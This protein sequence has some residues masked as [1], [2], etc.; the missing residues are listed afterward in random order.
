VTL[1]ESLPWEGG[2][3]RW[4]REG[5]GPPVVLCHGTPWSSEVWAHAATALR[6]HFTVYRWDMLGYGSSMT[7]TGEVSLETQGRVLAALLALW[8]AQGMP[9]PQIVAHDYGGAVALRAHLLH[10]APLRSLAL[11]DVVALA[12][13]G[14]DF[15]RLVREHAEVFARLPP[16]LHD[17]LVRAYVTGAV[18]R[19][20]TS[21]Q[22]DLLVAPWT[23]DKG[24]VAFYR[25]IAAA[26]QRWTDEVEPLY[27]TLDLPTL[28][29]WGTDDPWIPVDRAHRLA[30]LIPGAQLQL[31]QD[32]GH[33]VPMEAPE[34]LLALLTDWLARHP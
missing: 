32:A 31:V 2:Q 11:V 22:L 33:L 18:H 1:P 28:V 15:F 27:G 14:S 20:L 30:D 19:A 7:T 25:Q 3:V 16:P 9:V 34:E 5:S 10:G 23:T 21:E 29:V 12:P 6:E 4:G 13:W 17:A 24:Q 26:D 8:R